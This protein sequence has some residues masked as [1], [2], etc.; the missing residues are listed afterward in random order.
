MGGVNS[1]T[2]IC[3]MVVWLPGQM[4]RTWSSRHFP[5]VDVM[6]FFFFL[7]ELGALV[8]VCWVDDAAFLRGRRPYLLSLVLPP[9]PASPA[10]DGGGGDSSG[11]GVCSRIISAMSRKL[12][13]T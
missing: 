12:V 8:G 10:T 7:D 1:I 6:I 5:A 9:L 2:P 13:I 3:A 4:T 11:T